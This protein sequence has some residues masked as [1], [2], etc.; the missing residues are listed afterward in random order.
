[1]ASRSGAAYTTLAPLYDQV[2]AGKDYDREVR[3]IRRLVEHWGRPNSRSLLDVGC[4]TGRHLRG[5]SRAFRCTGLD[6]SPAMLRVA[7]RHGRGVRFLRGDME[8]FELGEKFDVVTCL[9][10][11]IGYVRTIPRLRRT[12]RTLARHTHPGGVLIVDPWLAPGDF[13]DGYLNVRVRDTPELKIARVGRNRRRGRVSTTEFGY[14]IASTDGGV[15]IFRETHALGLFT[16]AEQLAA[17]QSAGFRPRF[18][19]RGFNRTRGLFVGVR[20]P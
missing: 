19:R 7:R 10:G 5:L 13:R 16:T 9:F 3:E 14:A 1:M 12:L 18:Y 6:R 11:A 15:R 20:R 8:A 2:Y 4:G 17:F